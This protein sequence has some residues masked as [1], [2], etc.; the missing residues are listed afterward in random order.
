MRNKAGNHSYYGNVGAD[1]KSQ[2]FLQFFFANRLTAHIFFR[3]VF[4]QRAVGGGVVKFFVYSVE[5][6]FKFARIAVY[7]SVKPVREIRIFNFVRVS[8]AYGG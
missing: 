4:K 6:A 5:Y 1:G 8:R 3:I 7:Y 2:H